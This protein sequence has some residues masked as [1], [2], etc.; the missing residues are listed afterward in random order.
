MDLQRAGDGGERR[1]AEGSRSGSIA[2]VGGAVAL[3]LAGL[4]GAAWALQARST[5]RV[6]RRTLERLGR[7][8]A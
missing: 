3:G 2:L 6:R 5:G 4:L 1:S 8:A 7:R